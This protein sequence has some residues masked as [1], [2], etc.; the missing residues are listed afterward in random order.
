VNVS[1]EPALSPRYTFTN[2]ELQRFF[3]AKWKIQHCE[4]CLVSDWRV[5]TEYWLSTLPAA[6]GTTVS[7]SSDTVTQ[8]LRISCNSCGNTKLLLA[9]VVRHWLDIPP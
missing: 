5:D 2:E 1:D 4:I 8:H 7:A 3:A 6:D 9:A